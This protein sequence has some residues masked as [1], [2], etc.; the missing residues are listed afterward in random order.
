MSIVPASV[1]QENEQSNLLIAYNRCQ[2][3]RFLHRINGFARVPCHNHED[4]DDCGKKSYL[5]GE[6][7]W[8]GVRDLGISVNDLTSGKILP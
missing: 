3:H 1:T 4:I 5:K 7:V 6:A 2:R 8:D